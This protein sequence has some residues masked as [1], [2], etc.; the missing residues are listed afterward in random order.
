[1]LCCTESAQEVKLEDITSSARNAEILRRVRDDLPLIEETEIESL[2]IA[3]NDCD[4]GETFV[5]KEY[6]DWGWLGYFIGKSTQIRDLA[7]CCLPEEE[8]EVDAFMEG[9]KRNRSIALIAIKEVPFS[10][11]LFPFIIHN[12]NLKELRLLHTSIG[13]RFYARSLAMALKKRQQKSLTKLW[14]CNTNLSTE[15]L[16]E[17]LDALSGYEQLESLLVEEELIVRDETYYD[18]LAQIID[19]NGIASSEKNAEILRKLRDNDY[20]WDKDKVLSVGD[21]YGVDEDLCAEEGDDWGWLGYFLGQNKQARW[22]SLQYLPEDK[23]EVD[24]FMDGL[25]R[26]NSLEGMRIYFID[27]DFNQLSPFVIHN[28]SLKDL[29]LF[30][31]DIGLENARRLAMALQKRQHKSLTAF[32][33]DEINIEGE[34]LGEIT[35]ALSDYSSLQELCVSDTLIGREGCESLGAISRSAASNL[36]YISFVENDLDDEDLQTLVAA[37]AYA[38]S[39]RLLDVSCNQSITAAGLRVVSRLF[40]SACPLETLLLEGMNIGDEGA[41]ILADGLVGNTSLKHLAITPDSAGITSSGWDAF[42]EL[43][44]N[45]SSINNTYQSNHTLEHIGDDYHYTS[46]PDG[47]PKLFCSTDDFENIPTDVATYLNVN[48]K[49]SVKDAAKIKIAMCHPDIPVEVFFQYK[50]KLLPLLVSWLR[51]FGTPSCTCTCGNCVSVLQIRELSA[52]YK[53]IR[54]MPMLAVDG[55]LRLSTSC[56]CGRKRKYQPRID[57]IFQKVEQPLQRQRR[58]EAREE[59]EEEANQNVVRRTRQVRIDTIFRPR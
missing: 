49:Y 30:D 57:S 41:E 40:H 8:D 43:L 24:A 54:G 52:L 37:L 27:I 44:C 45:D 38:S 14:L 56:Q 42:L 55:K 26:N 32:C 16:A 53:F 36:Q 10:E 1:M 12:S 5:V 11:H 19:L 13:G 20:V 47:G 48:E 34:A 4:D 31:I 35:A 2:I 7:L 25:C 28:G 9:V 17:I 22:L 18:M 29:R 50:L 46:N 15:A 6:D 21:Y 58:N 3:G 51:I 39:L 33:L 59:G 23:D